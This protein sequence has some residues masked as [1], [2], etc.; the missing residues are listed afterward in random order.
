[1]I[2]SALAMRQIKWSFN[3]PCAPNF[4]GLWEAS[5]KSAKR[6]LYKHVGRETYT[7]EQLATLFCRVEAILNS[8]PLTFDV[9]DPTD[10][11]YLSPGH[12][13]IGTTLLST[14]ELPLPETRTLCGRFERMKQISQA[15]WKRWHNEYLCTLTNRYK[16]RNLTENAKLHQLV[17]ITDVNTSPLCWPLGRI[18][19]LYP[20]SDQIVRV[21]KVKTSGGEYVRPVNKLVL[22]KD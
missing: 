20:G 17:Y 14:P 10:G 8:R 12:F 5:V 7:F 15:I 11:D 21:V 22:I 1:M 6:L 19:Q 18:V 16:W 2:L 13:L 9:N 4:G 3:P